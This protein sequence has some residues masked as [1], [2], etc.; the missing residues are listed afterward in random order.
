MDHIRRRWMGIGRRHRWFDAAVAVLLAGAALLALL[1]TDQ[2]G[3]ARDEAFYF[4]HA[5][6][7]QNWQVEVEAG[8]R[9]REAALQRDE[10]L[11]VW[12][13][14][15]EHPPLDK[16]L[17]GWSW[18]LFGRKLREVGSGRQD[19]QGRLLADV[20][21][22]G[23]A[24]GF[25]VGR[26]VELLRPQLVGGDPAIGPRRWLRGTVTART[27]WSATVAFDGGAGQDAFGSVCGGAGTR[28]AAGALRRTGCEVVEDRVLYVLSESAA[29]RMPGMLFGALLVALVWAFARGLFG[30]QPLLARPFALLASAGYLLIPRAFFHAHLACFDMTIT[31]LLLATTFAYYHALRSRGWV[32]ITAVLWGVALLAKHNAFVLPAA[33]IGHWFWDAFAEG[34]VRL[35][36]ADAPAGRLALL[37][38]RPWAL[39]LAAALLLAG[40]GATFGLVVGLAA[41][42]L[43]VAAGPLRLA[44]PGLP[45]AWF[46]MLPVGL[47]LLVLGWP[48]LWVDTL[49]NLLAWLEFHL[50]HEHYMQ[51]YF[52][53]VLAYPPFPVAMPFVLTAL[54]WP[55]TLLVVAVAGLVLIA[56][57]GLRRLPSSLRAALGRAGPSAPTDPAARA[58]SLDR[59]LLIT[60]IWPVALIA[61]PN[62]PVFGGTKHWLTA[63]PA[64]LL[65]G[66]RALQ[67][68]WYGLSRRWQQGGQGERAAAA[69][70]AWALVAL[71]MLPAA[72]ATVRNHPQGTMYYNELIGGV[73]GA[74]RAGLQRQFWG[75]QARDGLPTVN[76]LAPPGA[77]IWMH[78]SAWGSFMMYQ[79]EG[80]CRRDLRYGSGPEGSALGL[81]HHQYDH[82]DYELDLFADYGVVA[83]VAQT[84]YEGVP[85]L[86]VYERPSNVAKRP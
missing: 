75:Y 15:S 23:P 38:H 45:L 25:A 70:A 53:Q 22:L 71:A 3:F 54:T 13:Q 85:L 76:A 30:G 84:A 4:G 69:V 80:W 47:L 34:R 19:E 21:G 1:A 32:W 57:V 55:V 28:D 86:S 7:Y 74:A 14:N 72:S 46:V 81:F 33:F 79:R 9:R 73:P 63:Y 2:M 50:H 11:R 26:P 12:R 16:L 51:T 24:H 66:A 48:L 44:L 5:E 37:L 17:F 62:T 60:A 36:R 67:W 58:R 82:D 39:A 68:A 40:L 83:P 52:G 43:V 64:L 77:R 10:I 27:P 59:L 78:N 20:R 31:T 65:L 42:A 6:T 56:A 8:G 29:M 49:H 18:R 35:L 61:M 41:A